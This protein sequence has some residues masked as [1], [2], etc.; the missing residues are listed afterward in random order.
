[1]CV[2]VVCFLLCRNSQIQLKCQ[3][4]GKTGTFVTS[5]FPKSAHVLVRASME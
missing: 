1:M 2:C 3:Q 5:S 4:N